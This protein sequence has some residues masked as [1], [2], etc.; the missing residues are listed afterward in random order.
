MFWSV[1]VAAEP[2][3]ADLRESLA[4]L[5]QRQA[6]V[7]EPGQTVA[8]MIASRLKGAEPRSSP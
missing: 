3:L 1:A 4:G 6:F 2:D 7:G 5:K 8:E